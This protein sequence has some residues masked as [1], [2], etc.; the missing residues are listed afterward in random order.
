[1]FPYFTM[2]IALAFTEHMEEK[3][4]GDEQ[5]NI[6]STF[7]MHQYGTHFLHACS[8]FNLTTTL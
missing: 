4:D 7:V 8:H 5:E 3:Q 2:F 6:Y 1:M